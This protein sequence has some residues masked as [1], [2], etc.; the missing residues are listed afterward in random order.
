MS[1][2]NIDFPDIPVRI[3]FQSIG[4]FVDDTMES[5]EPLMSLPAE[6]SRKACIR[7]YDA[8]VGITVSVCFADDRT[9][10]NIFIEPVYASHVRLEISRI[11][12]INII[13]GIC[14]DVSEA[15]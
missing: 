6:D 10:L 14:F 3:G 2:G 1:R 15:V 12:L 7:G 4:F 8:A 5:P 9:A 13:A 11:V